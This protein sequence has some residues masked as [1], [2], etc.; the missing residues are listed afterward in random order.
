MS[1]A[2]RPECVIT[3]PSLRTA[4]YNILTSSSS[5]SSS[6]CTTISLKGNFPLDQTFWSTHPQEKPCMEADTLPKNHDM[7]L[8]HYFWRVRNAEFY[9]T[10]SLLLP[11]IKICLNYPK[12]IQIILNLTGIEA[13]P[14]CIR[15][16]SHIHNLFFA[17]IP[18]LVTIA[19]INKMAILSN[20]S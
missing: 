13:L 3:Q 19:R 16:S 6:P 10:P 20:I 11:L 5:S 9:P 4:F 17:K 18:P 7:N 14:K 1:V 2:S 8:C 12:L 15:K